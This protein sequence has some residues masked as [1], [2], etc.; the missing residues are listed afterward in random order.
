MILM[1]EDGVLGSS[2]SLCQFVH[3]SCYMGWPGSLNRLSAAKGLRPMS[4]A[5]GP[6]IFYFENN[7]VA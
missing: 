1:G 4:W 7:S 5:V 2:L 6:N 3:H